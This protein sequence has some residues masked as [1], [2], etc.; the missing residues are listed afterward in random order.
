MNSIASFI[1][2][3]EK[4]YGSVIS[5]T[6]NKYIK[7]TIDIEKC[8]LAIIFINECLNNDKLP[9]FSHINIPSYKKDE[10]YHNNT[11]LEI[12]KHQLKHHRFTKS[13]LHNS[14]QKDFNTI[15]F[16]L[17]PGEWQDLNVLMDDKVHYIRIQTQ[18]R[19]NKKLRNLG[20]NI[21]KSYTSEGTLTKSRDFYKDTSAKNIVYNLSDRTLSQIEINVLKKGLKYGIKSKKVD[22]YEILSRF[23]LLARSFDKLEIVEEEDELKKQLDSKNSFL[24]K[25]Q[26]LAF[27][28][29]ELSKKTRDN[30]TDDEKSALNNLSKDH[31]II[32]NKADKGAAVVVQNKIDYNNKIMEI[33][34]QHDKFHKLDYDPTIEREAKLRNQLSRLHS[35]KQAIDKPTLKRIIP[36]GS[37]PG[38]M[39]GL[40]KIHKANSPIRPIISAVGTY[41]YKLA[42]YLV[43]IL[44]PLLDDNVI[45]IKD[46]FDFVNKVSNIPV[47]NNQRIISFD[48]VSLFTNIPVNE[49]IDLILKLCYTDNNKKFHGFSETELKKLLI[50]C[51]QKSHFQFNNEYYEQVDGVSMGSPL[52]PFFANIFMSHLE[53]LH[54]SKLKALGV[55]SWHRYVDDVFAVVENDTCHLNILDI[56]N[57]IHKNI[58]FTIEEE[59][60]N[61]LPF[62]DALVRR[63]N[64]GFK[65]KLYQKSTFTGVYLNWT[66]LTSRKYKIS[67]IYCLMDRLWKLCSDEVSRF[68][69][70]EKLKVNLANNDYPEEVINYEINKFIQNRELIIDTNNNKDTP[71]NNIDEI[72]NNL[73]NIDINNN[74]ILHNDNNSLS[75]TDN[76]IQNKIDDNN[77]NILQNENNKEKEIK[78]CIVLPY[79]NKGDEFSN[80]LN[81]LIKKNYPQV[82]MLV[83]FKTQNAIGNLFPFKDRVNNVRLKSKVVYHLKCKDCDANYIG[84]TE[85]ILHHRLLE[86]EKKDKNSAIHQHLLLHK[87]HRFDFDNVEILDRADTDYKLQIKELLHINKMKPSLNSK[88]TSENYQIQTFIIGARN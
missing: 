44:T 64:D 33:L 63:T 1:N 53:S 74:D 6:I 60:N 66:S 73:Q 56:L 62:L 31:N 45:I 82:K 79:C 47:I 75:N 24:Q 16:T 85:R 2:N 12:T 43:E 42:K 25:L 57:S 49:T 4:I 87:S 36:S 27:E 7:T 52:G 46:V 26:S 68:E 50:T 32:I 9:N 22:T 38:V 70:I 69:E 55:I 10:L 71:L 84:K 40:S 19:H 59:Q 80:N 41:N 18:S 86:H 20:I 76:N 54:I 51:T 48:V 8:N 83:A 61:S 14:K 58:D 11:R 37:R 88:L 5:K 30:L 15:N 39:Y 81:K 28:F 29:I 3:I 35:T 13:T 21:T 77:N 17:T 78:R 72:T 23:E 65:T 34:N 67:L